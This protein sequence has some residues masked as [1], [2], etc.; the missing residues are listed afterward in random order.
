MIRVTIELISAVTGDTSEIGR[1]YIANVGGTAERGDYDVAVCRR[2]TTDVP[3]P[4]GSPPT[5][6]GRVT[7]YPRLAYNVWRLITRALLVAFP[8]EAR[9]RKRIKDA[10]T[11]NDAVMRGL[12]LLAHHAP[13]EIGAFPSSVCPAEHYEIAQAREWLDTA[14][15]EDT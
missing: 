8:E 1:M 12:Q 4:V 14:N 7:D 13:R 10:P 9:H 15:R 5:R 6:S 2:G 3:H 11:L